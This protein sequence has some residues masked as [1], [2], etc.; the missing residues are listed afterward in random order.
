MNADNRSIQGGGISG[1]GV[2]EA[3]EKSG[4]DYDLALKQSYGLMTDVSQSSWKMMQDRVQHRQNHAF[5]E[6]PHKH[7]EDPPSWWNYNYD[8]EFTC[9]HEERVGGAGDGPKWVCNPARLREIGMTR[10]Q[11]EG[12]GCLIY[13]VGSQGD[14]T[15]ETGMLDK[16]GSDAPCEIH[17]F[18]MEDFSEKIPQ[19]YRHQIHFH[20]WG[21]KR[22][23]AP[24]PKLPVMNKWRDT[25]VSKFVFHSLQETIDILGHHGRVMD[26]FKIDCEGCEYETY[27]DWVSADVDI[28]QILTE[29]HTF[30]VDRTPLAIFQTLQANNFV[31]FHKEANTIIKGSCFEYAFMKLHPEFFHSMASTPSVV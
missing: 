6:D 7:A 15:F 12:Q 16:L 24:D 31:T 28:R 5:P 1:G 9:M 19:Q 22:H 11:Q 29:I 21:F 23:G 13:S 10:M 4:A 25:D 3:P 8:P 14:F 17:I 20:A 30:K 18:D 27:Q 2:S 26:I